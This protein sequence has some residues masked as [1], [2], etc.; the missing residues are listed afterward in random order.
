MRI[1]KLIVKIII[2]ATILFS[3]NCVYYNTFYNAEKAFNEAEKGRK[4]TQYSRRGRVSTTGYKKAIEKSLIVVENSPNSK[5]YDDAVFILGVSYFYTKDYSKAERRFREILVNFP[6]SKYTKEC[7][8]YLGKTKLKLNDEDE[9]MEIFKKIFTTDFDKSFK[10]E[11]AMG[12]GSFYFNEKDYKKA[13]PYLLAVRD[14]LGSSE[15]K[16]IAQNLI[17]DGYFKQFKFIDALKAYQQILGLDPNKSEKYHSYYQ[18]AL[19][20]FN[21]MRISEGHDYLMKLINDDLYFDS[22][23]ALRLA[24]G[25]G[26]EYE[27]ELEL[28]EDVYLRVLEE[29]KIKRIS[30]IAS[31]RLGLIYQLDYDDLVEA[32]KYYDK[33]MELSRGSEVGKDAL[34]RSS[35]IGKLEVFARKLVVDSSTTQTMIDEAAFTQYQL[36]ELY[37]FSLEKPDTAILEMQYL[38]DSFPTAYDAPLA[39]ISISQMYRDY[40]SDTT[41]ADSLLH[42]M[43]EKY[44]KSD[45]IENALEVLELKGTEADSGYASVYLK[46]AEN[47]LIDEENVDSARYY[48]NFILDNYPESD[49]YLHAKFALIWITEMYESPGDSSLVYAYQEIVDSFPNTQWSQEA[50]KRLKYVPKKRVNRDGSNEQ[51]DSLIDEFDDGKGEDTTEYVDPLVAVYMDEDGNRL[52]WLNLRPRET[53]RVFEYPTEAYRSAW[54]GVLYYHI[55]LDFSGEVIDYV[56]KIKSDYEEINLEANA[57]VASMIFNMLD[58]PPDW[59]GKWAVYK[60]NV[61][62]PEHLR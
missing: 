33:T 17:S 2:L 50:Q 7:E 42:L 1:S 60:F 4:N 29:E 26:Y 3:V 32:K 9:A 38:I 45:F 13:L 43:I 20:S 25:M 30:S 6:E 11:A 46:K 40:K 49:Y 28:A 10:S 5:W 54:E 59:H 37:W 58:I 39:Y 36:A 41:A 55:L 56:L 52:K 61:R 35:D 57:T 19:C 23:G 18:S 14:S 53:R 12:L 51:P 44:P 62:L 47:F 48:Y 21:L 15:E 31:Y 34:T 27:N 22:L 8:I 24:V 16:K